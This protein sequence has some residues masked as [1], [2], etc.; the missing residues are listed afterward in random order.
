[1]ISAQDV[2]TNREHMSQMLRARLGLPDF[3]HD[4]GFA[5]GQNLVGG[6]AYFNTTLLRVRVYDGAQ[7]ITVGEAT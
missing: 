5:Q 1:M 6:E 3:P 7:F 2:S 4:D